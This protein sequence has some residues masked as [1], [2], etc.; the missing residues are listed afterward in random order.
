MKKIDLHIHTVQSVSDNRYFDFNIESLKEYV[1]L[2]EIDCIAITNHNLFDKI[3]FEHICQELNI[4]VFP[5]IEIDLESGHLLLI[6][7]NELLDDFNLKCQKVKDLIPTK[8][9][10]ISYEQLIEIFPNLNNYLLIPH[11]DK[12][13]N[14]KPNTITKFGDNIF[15]GEVTSLRKF[16]AC[17]KEAD[18]LTPVIFSD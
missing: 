3:Q 14:I 8:D 1:D 4:K 10:S 16:K 9:D 15:V 17:I 6:S 12:K 7:E 13:P 11:Y 18:K 5:G 2:L